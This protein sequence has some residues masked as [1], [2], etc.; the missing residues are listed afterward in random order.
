MD[1]EV[2]ATKRQAV[3]QLT[4]IEKAFGEQRVLD[5]VSLSVQN[6]EVVSIVGQ[7]GGGK[8]TLLRCINLLER[9]DKGKIVVAGETVF[10]GGVMLRERELERF[11][12][13]VGMVFQR[14]HLFPHLSAIENITLPLI[15]GLGTDP[16]AAV[17]TAHTLLNRV[18]LPKK[19]LARP[20]TLSGGEQQR[21][22][23]ARA[24]ALRPEVLL[25]DEPTSSLDPE[26]TAE[27]NKVMAELAADGMTMII[28]THELRFAEDAAD[29]LVFIDAGSIVEDG[30]VRDVLF[31][32]QQRRTQDFLRSFNR[33]S[34]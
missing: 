27:V 2:G 19:A 11:R 9:P 31:N 20:S 18:G 14:F 8:T 6:G 15:R 17:T 30:P 25:F 24:M 1:D 16:D 22:A 26:S 33:T 13:T 12:R 4:D 3:L 23:I 21:V 32:P 28:V 29:R 34:T 7:S 5:R 10:S